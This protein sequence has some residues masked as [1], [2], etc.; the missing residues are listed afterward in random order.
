MPGHIKLVKGAVDPDPTEYLLPSIEMKR[1]D[2]A[3][4]YDTK[5]SVW[6]MDAKTHVYKEGLLESGDIASLGAE[7]A[8]LSAKM[9]VAVG[10]DP[11]NV[12][13]CCQL[14][15]QNNRDEPLSTFKLAK[16]NLG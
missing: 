3:K 4:V 6:I 11:K 12:I 15:Q 16:P 7:G 10:R 14:V 1:E 9:V 2:Q 8:D 13:N 5:K